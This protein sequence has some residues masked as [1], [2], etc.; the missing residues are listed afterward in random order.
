MS[1][2]FGRGECEDDDIRHDFIKYYTTIQNDPSRIPYDE[3]GNLCPEMYSNP[4][5]F[6]TQKLFYDDSNI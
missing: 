1:N 5:K 3:D 4:E 6:I 2:N